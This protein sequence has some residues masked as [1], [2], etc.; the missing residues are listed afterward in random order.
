MHGESALSPG[1]T[2]VG[3]GSMSNVRMD[4][5][6]ALQ[7]KQ[8]LLR[9]STDLRN[10]ATRR[11]HDRGRRPHQKVMALVRTWPL[12][13]SCLTRGIAVYG[14]A[15]VYRRCRM[16][17]LICLSSSRPRLNVSRGFLDTVGV[18]VLFV[19]VYIGFSVQQLQ[20]ACVVAYV[21]SCFV[22]R[23]CVIGARKVG[24]V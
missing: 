5:G 11:K 1:C 16:Y 17:F 14:R 15:V 4:R 12:R 13:P 20:A 6:R 10:E 24:V 22:V 2:S 23:T 7:D 19:K 9:C 3:M 21:L 8:L 18:G